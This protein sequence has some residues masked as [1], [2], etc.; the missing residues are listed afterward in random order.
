LALASGPANMAIDE[1][2]LESVAA[3]AA[4]PTLRFYG[5][6][7]RWLSIG[8]AESIADVDRAACHETGTGV[9][10][11][12]SGGTAVLHLDQLAWSLTLPAGHSLAPGD[13]VAS[14]AQHAEITLAALRSVG[15]GA[16]AA[17]T[18]EA[19]A[20]LPDQLLQ[21]ACFGG[22]APHEIVVGDPPRKL[23]GWG[24]VRRR[25]VVMHH[26]ALSRRFD[27]A[28]LPALLATD[29]PG[30]SRA[31]ES[32]VVGLDEVA[33]R[34][35]SSRA[36]VAALVAAFAA[37]GHPTELATLTEDELVR[38]AELLREKYANEGWTARR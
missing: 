23:V 15:A 24:Q 18:A 19:R 16:R 29:R 5:W 36:L 28:A 2:I 17:S 1:A 30:L 37:V 25:A 31:L 33:G 10:R 6:R 11:R 12:P 4:P 7:G 8:M 13:I 26:A 9:V 35:V 14:Y 20:P 34:R 22:L 38:A 27:P 21:I 3:G 32:R